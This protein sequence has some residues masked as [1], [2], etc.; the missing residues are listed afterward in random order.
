MRIARVILRVSDLPAGIDFW[1][2]KVGLAVTFETP[3]FAFLEAGQT[4]LM[5]NQHDGY[6]TDALTELVLEVDDVTASYESMTARGVP[7][8]VEL[9]AVMSERSRELLAAH[10]ADPDGN[11]AS[12]TGWVDRG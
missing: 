1:S 4:Q 3:E 5:L 10:F 8:A 9:R 7:F 6:T 2:G 12:L 11:V